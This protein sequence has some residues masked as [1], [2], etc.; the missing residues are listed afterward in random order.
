MN[1]V[2]SIIRTRYR[3]RLGGRKIDETGRGL[4]GPNRPTTDL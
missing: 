3:E 2:D 1:L 4:S